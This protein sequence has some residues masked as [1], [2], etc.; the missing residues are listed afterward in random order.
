MKKMLAVLV[1]AAFV[2]TGCTGSFNLT[3][4]VNNFH[5]SQQ[6]DKWKDELCFL[7]V[8]LLPIYGLATF[9]DAIVFNSVEFWTGENPVVL[10]QGDEKIKTVKKGNDTIL[11][12]Y[13]TK[14]DEV[15]IVPQQN[16]MQ[17]LNL[18][19]F[20]DGSVAVKDSQGDLLYISKKNPNGDISVFDK[21]DKLVKNFSAEEV[22]LAKSTYF[23]K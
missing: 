23:K 5:R 16:K 9:A 20:Q 2:T 15:A 1:L 7:V 22:S 8:A 18:A 14:T 21:D 4:K 10:N 13:N 6:P 11:L 19:R 3:K 17:N 12:S